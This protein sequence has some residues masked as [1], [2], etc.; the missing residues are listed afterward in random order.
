MKFVKLSQILKKYAPNVRSVT[1]GYAHIKNN[2]GEIQD[3]HR[4]Q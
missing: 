4:I 1:L 2:V 3:C